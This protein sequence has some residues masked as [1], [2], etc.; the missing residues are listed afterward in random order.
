MHNSFCI[1]VFIDELDAIAPARKDGSEELSHR[2]VAT[3]L[4]LMDGI[5]RTDG[6]L[7]IAATNRPDSVEPALRR[8]GR[9]DREI[10][11]GDLKSFFLL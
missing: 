3:L 5:G 1:Q 11:I 4:N 6:L 7:V 2:M 8:P 10:E 9:F